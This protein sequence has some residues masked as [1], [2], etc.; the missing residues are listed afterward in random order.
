MPKIKY[1]PKDFPPNLGPSLSRP[2]TLDCSWSDLVW[3]TI[4]VGRQ[5]WPHVIRQGMYSYFE[6]VYRSAMLF[7]NLRGTLPQ[8]IK[9]LDLDI[10]LTQSPAYQ[11]LDPSEKSAV[12]Y[13]LGLIMSKLFAE[14][15]LGISWVLHLDT[16][17]QK[18]SPEI[19]GKSRPDLV[20]LDKKSNWIVI[21]AKG[22]SKELDKKAV[23][24]GKKQAQ[25]LTKIAGRKPTLYVGLSSYFSNN[26]EVFLQDPPLL[27]GENDY[28]LDISIN[29]Y[30]FDYYEPLID[31]LTS[32]YGD[33]E[34]LEEA[35]HRVY[36][37]KK[38]REVDLQVGLDTQ[39]YHL[40]L[41][42]NITETPNLFPILA[43]M[44]HPSHYLTST[45]L[46]EDTTIG[47]DRRTTIGGDGIYVQV[48]N[49]WSDENMYK[50][51]QER[52]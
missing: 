34:T 32:N 31:F 14:K 40:F 9:F 10:Y 50:S 37:T 29:R 6:I 52:Q 28:N 36:V 38:I 47:L 4:T 27:E 19:L 5:N 1:I 7:A 39:I 24:K 23:L 48:G 16:Y 21:E 46:I 45:N 49:S 22:R 11:D 41:Q 18:L 51:P 43:D 42:R 15:L 35:N 33:L 44:L 17:K 3:S 12:S 8:P 2:N 30:L 13:F 20:G 25:A 26:L